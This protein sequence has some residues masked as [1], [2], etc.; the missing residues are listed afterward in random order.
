[1]QSLSYISC[2]EIINKTN[3][4]ALHWNNEANAQQ[5]QVYF[6]NQYL[7]KSSWIEKSPF[8]HQILSL[9]I[10]TTCMILWESRCIFGPVTKQSLSLYSSGRSFPEDVP[11]QEYLF[12]DLIMEPNQ[13]RAKSGH[14]LAA[15]LM[16][17]FSEQY[18]ADLSSTCS[19]SRNVRYSYMSW[20]INQPSPG[21]FLV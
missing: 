7:Q 2:P 1:M 11:Q 9:S 17:V 16:T 5:Y 6:Q 14:P 20:Q 10:T 3:P 21:K 19:K 4:K 12:I 13:G 8:C 18:R 15:F